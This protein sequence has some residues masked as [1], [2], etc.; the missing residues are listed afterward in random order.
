MCVAV[1]L[2]LRAR[3]RWS[4]FC[5]GGLNELFGRVGNF[6][7]V[8]IWDIAN[9]CL[10]WVFCWWETVWLTQCLLSHLL[11]SLV[12]CFKHKGLEL[13]QIMHLTRSRTVHWRST[14]IGV[15]V[16]NT[17]YVI[18]PQC[19]L[20]ISETSQQFMQNLPVTKEIWF[21]NEAG[22][23]WNLFRNDNESN[24]TLTMSRL[25]LPESW[26]KHNS[27]SFHAIFNKT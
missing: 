15:R 22:D 11:F 17:F 1:T 24:I 26:R 5:I 23:G 2:E 13:G 27:N 9:Y 4:L 12:F 19:R 21:P 7:V 14:E 18:P 8:I 16:A 20:W 3:L 25:L 6:L 10:R